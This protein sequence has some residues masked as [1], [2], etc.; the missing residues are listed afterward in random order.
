MPASDPV[1]VPGKI[2]GLMLTLDFFERC[3]SFVSFLP[4]PVAVGS[5]PT[6]PDNTWPTGKARQHE[7]KPPLERVEVLFSKTRKIGKFYRF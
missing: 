3:H 6:E 7:H 5:R 4:L 1:A 2:I